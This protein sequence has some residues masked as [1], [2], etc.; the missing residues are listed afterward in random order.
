[1]PL[2]DEEMVDSRLS[3]I[4]R[5]ANPGNEAAAHLKLSL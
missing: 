4:F 5:R 3:A 2:T 1:M